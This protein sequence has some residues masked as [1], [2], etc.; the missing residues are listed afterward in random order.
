MNTGLEGR[1]ALVCGASAG[2]GYAI[3]LPV[4]GGRSHGL[5]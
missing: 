1:V 3:A 5:L 4:D 2:I